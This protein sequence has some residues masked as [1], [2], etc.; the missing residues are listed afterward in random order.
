MYQYLRQNKTLIL[1]NINFYLITITCNPVKN[2]TSD[3]LHFILI[4]VLISL[5]PPL[6][7]LSCKKKYAI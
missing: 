1:F 7:H 2:K 4:P 5:H 6:S 3:I